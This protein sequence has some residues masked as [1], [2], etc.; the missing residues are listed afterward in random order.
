[1]KKIKTITICSRASHYRQVLEIEKEL[2]KLGFKIKIPKTAN[3]MKRNNDFDVSHY[4]TWFKN[5][6]D[7]HKKTKLMLGHFKK[8]IESDAILI[9]N[10]EK[11]GIKGYI[12]GN[13]LMEMLVAFLNKK[14]IYIYNKPSEKL[15]TIEEIYG[16]KP[17]IINGDLTK[18]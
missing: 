8:V 15:S 12:G 5:K 9:T 18:I 6:N 4:K 3:T 17:K 13:T 16:L 2:K 11:N 10:F 7:Y 1:M 14:P